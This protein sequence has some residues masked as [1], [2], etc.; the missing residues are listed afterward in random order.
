VTHFLPLIIDTDPGVDDALALAWLLTQPAYDIHVLGIGIVAGNTSV[1]NA[2]RNALTILH[3]IQ[4][5]NIP[6]AI[7]ATKPRVFLLS[8]SNIL[9]HGPDGLWGASQNHALDT[10]A[11]DVAAF[12]RDLVTANPGATLLT[13]GP[14][15]NVAL[16][17]EQYPQAM[18]KLGRLLILGGTKAKGSMTP[19]S[20]YNFWQDPHAAKIVLASGLPITLL[21]RDAFTAFQLSKADLAV[22]C[23]QETAVPAILRTPIRLY[24]RLYT[25][26]GGQTAA[27]IPD[28]A[29]VLVAVDPTL[30]STQPALVKMITEDGLARGQTIIG[31]TF[32]EQVTMIADDEEMGKLAQEALQDPA[33][34]FQARL[35][36]ILMREPA[37]VELVTAVDGPRMRQIFL[38]TIKGT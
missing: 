37:N 15:T 16:A 11:T 31:Q 30:T 8:Q 9:I 23:E 34:D 10:C 22:I 27:T 3:T 18:A 24:T 20:E 29:A 35:A 17:I 7:G 4:Q 14:L 13:M 25:E 26:V 1:H 33:F 21:I 5:P 12:Y 32:S 2:A 6:I 28:L 38:D 19:V 36:E